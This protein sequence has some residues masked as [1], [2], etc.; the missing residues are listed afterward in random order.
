MKFGEDLPSC[1]R[2]AMQVIQYIEA[3]ERAMYYRKKARK[4]APASMY[5]ITCMA[6]GR[7]MAKSSPNFMNGL[8][9]NA[10]GGADAVMLCFDDLFADQ[11]HPG[12]SGIAT[13]G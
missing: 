10:R 6:I 2:S 12:N 5:W 11:D 8:E 3:G 9:S 7:T 1:G 4:N 13:S